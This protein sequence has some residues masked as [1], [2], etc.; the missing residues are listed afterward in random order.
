MKPTENKTLTFKEAFCAI[1][2]CPPEDYTKRVLLR[3]FKWHAVL[4]GRILLALNSPSIRPAIE[5]V[6]LLEKAEDTE[7]VVLIANDYRYQLTQPSISRWVRSLK[8]R[9]GGSRMV[10]LYRQVKQ[11]AAVLDAQSFSRPVKGDV[12]KDSAFQRPIIAQI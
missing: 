10:S 2:K 7:E 6:T 11:E 12:I 4:I 9:L 5:A 1:Y 3:S 8:I